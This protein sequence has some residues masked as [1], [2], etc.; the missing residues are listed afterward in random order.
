ME[1]KECSINTQTHILPTMVLLHAKEWKHR[2]HM[3]ECVRVCH[4][5]NDAGTAGGPAFRCELNC[6]FLVF[7]CWSAGIH[8]SIWRKKK[9]ETTWKWIVEI[10]IIILY[11]FGWKTGFRF[12]SIPIWPNILLTAASPSP[13]SASFLF[14]SILRAPF[15]R[16]RVFS[17]RT[18]FDC[19]CQAF[20][21]H[22]L[23]MN[24][25]IH[26]HSFAFIHIHMF[27]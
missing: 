5:G 20:A 11:L 9:A 19:W 14:D 1:W 15:F 7:C 8:L 21:L 16:S 17:S 27:S 4:V 24:F 25:H 13:F 3:C 10:F 12:S 18:Q 2:V 6:G 23:N 26:S 22:L